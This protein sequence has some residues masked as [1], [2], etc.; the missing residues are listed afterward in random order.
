MQMLIVFEPKGLERKAT[1]APAHFALHG[2]SNAPPLPIG[3]DERE[4]TKRQGPLAK[5]VGLYAR[6]LENRKYDMAEH[7]PFDEYARGVMASDHNGHSELKED[8]QLKKLF[9][10][11][12]LSGLGPGLYWEP[13]KASRRERSRSRA[14]EQANPRQARCNGAA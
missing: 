13:A 6:S 9:P 11:C 8:V 5:L 3:Y 14:A 4:H 1:L 2:P 12:E 10:P 7:P